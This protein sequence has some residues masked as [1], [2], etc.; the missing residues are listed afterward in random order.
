MKLL[1]QSDSRWKNVQLGTCK[2][3]TIGSAGCLIT[4]IAML[5]GTTPDIINNKAVYYRGCLLSGRATVKALDMVYSAVRSRP[6]R[7]PCIAEVKVPKGQHFVVIDGS[8]QYD[9]L[10]GKISNYKILSYRNLSPKIKKDDINESVIRALYKMIKQ[11]PT[12][13]EVDKHLRAR[14]YTEL[15]SGFFAAHKNIVKER[16]ILTIRKDM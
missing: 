6:V 4:C 14:T 13:E 12:Q 1:K 15:F 5:L 11:V 3:E 16:I 2:D 8:R 7:L 10:T 9:P